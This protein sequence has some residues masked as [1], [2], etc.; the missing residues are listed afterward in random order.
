MLYLFP[1]FLI[2]L[3]WSPEEKK[4]F[5]SNQLTCLLLAVV[6]LSC[7]CSFLVCLFVL[8]QFVPTC[9]SNNSFLALVG[10]F[11]VSL[12]LLFYIHTLFMLLLLLY[13]CFLFLSLYFGLV[14]V[15]LYVLILYL[16]G[17]C[18]S[19]GGMLSSC[20]CVYVIWSSGNNYTFLSHSRCVCCSCFCHRVFAL[21][22]CFRCFCDGNSDCCVLVLREFVGS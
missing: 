1:Y 14:I 21:W 11:L 22:L 5:A 12:L 6:C 13:W 4:S 16:F 7:V 2:N 18:W 15:F 8:S 17:Y 9:G 3:S 20:S 10:V 19:I